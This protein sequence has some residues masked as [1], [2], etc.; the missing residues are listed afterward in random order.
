MVF[1]FFLS[2]N[3]LKKSH[4]GLLTIRIDFPFL[5]EDEQQPL[6][7]KN[8]LC[9]ENHFTE[10][11][12]PKRELCFY[13]LYLDPMEDITAKSEVFSVVQHRKKIG[14]QQKQKGEAESNNTDCHLQ[15]LSCRNGTS[16]AFHAA[17]ETKHKK[18]R[19]GGKHLPYQLFPMHLILR[20]SSKIIH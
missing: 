6:S 19:H 12:I 16:L 13:S 1:F 14:S 15:V 3:E 5:R 20:P 18:I 2:L 9:A 8:Y 4:I 7:D 11:S 17:S 10:Y